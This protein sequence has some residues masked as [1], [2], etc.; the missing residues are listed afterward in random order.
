MGPFAFTV[1]SLGDILSTAGYVRKVYD[2]LA[3]TPDSS[4][5]YKVL[6]RE[7]DLFSHTLECVHNIFGD[8]ET[9]EL[10]ISF[11]SMAQAIEHALVSAKL[12]LG[13]LYA[14]TSV[15]HTSMRDG[16][17]GSRVQDATM[18]TVWV[19]NERD[20]AQAVQQLR[21]LVG[22]FHTLISVSN[23]FVL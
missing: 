23:R 10:P 1:G 13:K 9:E 18:K 2:A 12:L 20:A 14:S 15:Y 17:S 21:H 3:E 6:L 5:R 4:G 7:L 22:L 19:L 11:A 8:R 16:G